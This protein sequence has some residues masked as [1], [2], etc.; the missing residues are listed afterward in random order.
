MK[1]DAM[2]TCWIKSFENPNNE[3]RAKSNKKAII[4]IGNNLK[5]ISIK[6]IPLLAAIKFLKILYQI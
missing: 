4:Q 3:I 1:S 6:A 5:R 2:F